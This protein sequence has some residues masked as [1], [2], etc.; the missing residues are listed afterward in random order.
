V[1][2]GRQSGGSGAMWAKLDESEIGKTERQWRKEKRRFPNPPK[3][4]G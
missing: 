1:G 3:F 2:V 4:F